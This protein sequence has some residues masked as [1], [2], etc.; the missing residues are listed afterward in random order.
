MTKSVEMLRPPRNATKLVL[1]ATGVCFFMMAAGPIVKATPLH[2]P[3]PTAVSRV[4][5]KVHQ[6]RST[7]D[8][9]YTLIEYTV[10]TAKAVPHIIAIDEADHVWFS[11]SGGRFARNF[12][13]TEPLNKVARLDQGGTVSEW[14]LDG[15]G[16]SPM[17]VLFDARGDLWITERLGNRLTRLGRD[18][19][20][21]QYP[22]PSPGAWPT[23]IAIDPRGRIWF[24][25]TK[26][27]KIGVIDP[28]TGQMTEYPLPITAAMATGIAAGRDGKIWVAERDVNIIGRL[29]PDTASFTQYRLPTKDSKPCAVTVDDA[30]NVWFSERSGGKIG[31]IGPDGTIQEFPLPD[32]FAGPFILAA[33]RNRDVWF[34]ELFSG[35]IGRF[36]PASKS[37]EHFEIPERAAHPA[38]VA[39][40]S[41]GNVW[42]A[43]Q[44]TNKLAVI[45][46]TDLAYIAGERTPVA[47]TP[48]AAIPEHTIR[49]FHIPTANAI[50][51]IVAVD[52][53]DTVWFTEMGGGFVG[54]G[55]PPGPPGEKIGYI[56]QGVLHELATPTSASGPTSLARDPCGDD[57]WVSLRA[58][59][60]IARVRDFA[61]TEFDLPVRDSMPVGVAVD[62]DHNV[63]VALSEANAL[64]RRTAEGEWRVLPL[65]EPDAQPRTVFVDARGEVWF[66]EKT[67]NHIGRVDRDAWTVRRWEIPT[68]LAW[69]L[70]LDGDSH[71]NIWFA[72]M[73]SDKLAMF[74][75]ATEKITEFQ[76]PVQSAPFKILYDGQHQSFWISTVFANAILRFD[77]MAKKITAVFKVPHEGAWVGG[78]DRDSSGCIWFSE[79]FA[80]RIGRLCVRGIVTA[81]PASR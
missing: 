17:G 66:A 71:G 18:G 55:F 80:N 27:D 16:T 24:T 20:T 43:Q 19:R 61:I 53:H 38:G 28:A 74:D 63:W 5:I 4:E 14:T 48:A 76:L 32:R 7:A 62:Q 81:A 41:K 21:T 60:K 65:P 58:A 40:D 75:P 57:I 49:E 52:R 36:N 2:F 33:D 35:R 42:F 9:P 37:F 54:P 34:S 39:V 31:R 78:L 72:Q 10:P 50:P 70:S 64:A 22:L 51:G 23:G 45:V 12:I 11:E 30:G 47:V 56:R 13:D 77:L 25:Q 29:D 79:Q 44:S 1:V 6:L 46:R 68:R 67:G 69:P 73:R 8:R 26:V 3:P 59:N 15:T